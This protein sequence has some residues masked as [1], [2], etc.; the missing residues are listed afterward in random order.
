MFLEIEK[1]KEKRKENFKWSSNYFVSA[2]FVF[3]NTKKKE[4]KNKNANKFD[5]N[6]RNFASNVLIFIII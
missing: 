6:E 4:W 1:K 5:K 2:I 3:H